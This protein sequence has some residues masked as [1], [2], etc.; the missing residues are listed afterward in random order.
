M[1]DAEMVEML[2]AFFT[3]VFTSKT[4]PWDSWT[5]EGRE[6]AWEM[7][8]FPLGEDGVIW[9]HLGGISVHKSIDSDG[10]HPHVRRELAEVIAKLCHL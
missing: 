4:A 5:L 1:G 9:E 10:M 3:L 8:S 2:N 7:E 6:K